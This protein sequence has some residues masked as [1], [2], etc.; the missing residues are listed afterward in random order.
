M[1]FDIQEER[2]APVQRTAPTGSVF[3]QQK[4]RL[5]LRI[6]VPRIP[7]VISEIKVGCAMKF[8]GAWFGEDLDA[9]IAQLVVFRGKGILIDAHLANRLLGGKLPSAESVYIDGAAARPGGRPGQSLQIRLEVFRVIRQCGK[10]VSTQDQGS[11]VTGGISADC[12]PRGI[13]HRHLL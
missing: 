10:V 6:R 4:R 5:L 11:G 12:W 7:E 9:A 13:L 2:G 8:V 3:L 1:S